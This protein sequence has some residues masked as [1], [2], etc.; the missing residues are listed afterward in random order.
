M[1]RR[2][3]LRQLCVKGG[4]VTQFAAI[5]CLHR[6]CQRRRTRRHRR[7]GDDGGGVRGIGERWDGRRVAADDLCL[8]LPLLGCDFV[9]EYTNTQI[10]K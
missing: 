1:A 4:V 3:S 10:H 7:C 9:G 8:L 5:H 2:V 6:R